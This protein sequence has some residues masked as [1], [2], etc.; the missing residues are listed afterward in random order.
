MNSGFNASRNLVDIA[1]SFATDYGLGFCD[2]LNIIPAE[3]FSKK[4]LMYFSRILFQD[5][6]AYNSIEFGNKLHSC[7]FS[8]K[9]R[10]RDICWNWNM[11]MVQF[12]FLVMIKFF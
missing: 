6:D 3:V 7:T 11:N 5:Y 9:L 8:Q 10:I 2:T 1:H 4:Y 12:L